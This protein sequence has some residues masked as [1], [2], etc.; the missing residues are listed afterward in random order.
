MSLESDSG[1]ISAGENRRTRRKT[2][3]S[4]TLSTTNPTWIFPGA[5]PGLRGEMPAT[6]DLSH[7]TATISTSILSF[8]LYLGLLRDVF[9]QF[10]QLKCMYLSSPPCSYPVPAT[11]PSSF[12]QRDSIYCLI[13]SSLQIMKLLKICVTRACRCFVDVVNV[14]AQS[15]SY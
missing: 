9:L 3:P 10:S 7:S 4:A 2:C 5:N 12:Y 11:R 15:G 14:L 13:N 1:M 8:H 6:T